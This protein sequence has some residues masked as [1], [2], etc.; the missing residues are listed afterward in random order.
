MISTIQQQQRQ[1]HTI[2]L[3]HD[4]GNTTSYEQMDQNG[5]VVSQTTAGDELRT[6]SYYDTKENRIYLSS[7]LPT[8]LPLWSSNKYCSIYK[9]LP[10][11]DAKII[12][13]CAVWYLSSVVSNSTTKLI[14]KDFKYPLTLTEI[15]FILNSSLCLAL[16]RFIRS[17]GSFSEK[18]S[19]GTFPK[20]IS[21]PNYSILKNFLKPTRLI[22]YTTLPMGIFQFA[23]HIASHK[24]T[25]II[26]VSLVHTIKALSPLTTVLIY[27]VFFKVE[28][29]FKTYLTLIPLVLGVMFSCL[30]NNSSIADHLFFSGCIFAFASML[31]FVLQNI[32][33][34]KILTFTTNEIS[35]DG[36][37]KPPILPT[38]SN[39]HIKVGHGLETKLDKLTILFYCSVIG[40]MLT[41]PI[42]TIS[43]LSNI[44]HSDGEASFLRIS[45]DT[46]AL[47]LL[48]GV[49][50]FIQSLMA[51]QIL[52]LISPVSYSIVSILKR[53]VVITC[54]IIL[55]RQS[56]NCLQGFGLV[57]TV[58]GLYSYDKW[59]K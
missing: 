51:F 1:Q 24:A 56:F 28:Y 12:V 33:T 26:P 11:F 13:L 27:R 36:I 52:G 25:S 30:K 46:V 6:Y 22:I 55:E 44:F 38:A 16:V 29:S 19:A 59:G 5:Q 9:F 37:Q 48:N 35:V 47:M 20:N 7:A 17:C 39:D 18:F 57:L 8:T 50:H 43:E 54:S 15:Q 34:K 4:H 10:H 53:I 21:D 23:G 40:F 3:T 32:F 2:S 14:L 45:H 41:L 58:A 42:Y 49:S 31:I